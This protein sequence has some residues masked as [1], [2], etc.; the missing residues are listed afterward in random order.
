MA[1][2]IRS[3]YQIFGVSVRGASHV[4]SGKECQDSCKSLSRGEASILSV[5]DGHGSDACPYSKD[6]S[7]IAVNVFC[8]I[9]SDYCDRYADD[10]EPLLTFLNREGDTKVAQ[11]IDQEWKRRVLIAH[12][13]NGRERFTNDDG[14][15]NDVAVY[16][17]YGTT[18]L[19]L[20]IMPSFLFA[21]QLGDGDMAYASDSGVE[22]L[23]ATEKILGTETHSLSKPDAWK[24]AVTVTKRTDTDMPELPHIF[25]LTTDGFANS[26]TSEEEYVKSIGEYYKLLKEYGS[27][28]VFDN[29]EQWLVETSELGCGDDITALIAYVDG[30]G[31]PDE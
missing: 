27:K 10:H 7:E 16:R 15:P 28:A 20:L 8:D 18:L 21:F 13:D 5:A 12:E 14:T 26:Y 1:A 17:Q 4:R 24:R 6:G 31:Q 2:Q 19:G 3:S 30:E 22:P 11:A 25:M 29:I 9:M 23:I